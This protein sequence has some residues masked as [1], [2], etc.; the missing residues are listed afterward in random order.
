MDADETTLPFSRTTATLAG[1]M[2]G[3]REDQL[4]DPTPCP[5][6]TVGDLAHHVVGLTAA[7]TAA[8]RKDRS[9][10]GR[11]PSPADDELPER[12]R[13]RIGGQLVDLASAWEESAAYTGLTMAGPVE[14]PG[15]EAGLVA[16]DEVVIHAWDLAAATGQPYDADPAA[17]E[18]VQGFV[19]SFEPP[20][21]GAAEGGGLFGPRVDVPEDA[22]A[23]HRLLG[24]TG[25]DPQWA[26][27]TR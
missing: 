8:A 14:M 7:F 16:L 3:V 20:P 24:L 11:S 17:V 10:G 12:W 19:A 9:L 21:G 6:W 22:S 26:P 27:P 25:R 13:E 1:L 15:R 5:D 2:A 23:L 18:L 4:A